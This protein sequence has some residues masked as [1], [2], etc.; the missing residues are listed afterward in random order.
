MEKWTVHYTLSNNYGKI[1]STLCLIDRNSKCTNIWLKCPCLRLKNKS[2]KSNNMWMQL[3]KH[4]NLS[5]NQI[6]KIILLVFVPHS[7]NKHVKNFMN[8]EIN[9]ISSNKHLQNVPLII[10]S[11]LRH[12]HPMNSV[13][14]CTNAYCLFLTLKKFTNLSISKISNPLNIKQFRIMSLTFHL[15]I[16]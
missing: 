4:V 3:I 13:R 10:A 16:P 2:I 11:N 5:K 12:L 8:I 15:L 14:K 7:I 1:L 6:K 9:S